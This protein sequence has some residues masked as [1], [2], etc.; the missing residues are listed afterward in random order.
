MPET[1]L[2]NT[3]NKPRQQSIEALNAKTDADLFEY[4]A[5][6]NKLILNANLFTAIARKEMEK[7]FEIIRHRTTA[8][9]DEYQKLAGR[10]IE[11]LGRR[12]EMDV[13]IRDK[14]ARQVEEEEA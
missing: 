9:R 1:P 3:I 14:L 10:A 7:S 5:E 12:V 11:I 4:I 2:P 6:C 8:G 13:A